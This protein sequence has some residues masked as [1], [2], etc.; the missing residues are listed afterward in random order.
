M[1]V[2]SSSDVIHDAHSSHWGRN[3][4]TCTQLPVKNSTTYY[5]QMQTPASH[6][7][8]TLFSQSINKHL[9]LTL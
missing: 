9:N 2:F 4:T 1:A 8:S 5:E 7:T 3:P 6:M